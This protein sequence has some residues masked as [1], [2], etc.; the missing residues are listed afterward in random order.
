MVATG[1][2]APCT[3][4]FREVTRL[5][6]QFDGIA[7]SLPAARGPGGT[8]LT[9]TYQPG[10]V[11]VWSAQGELIRVMGNGDGEGPGEFNHAS[12]LIVDADSVVNILP[13]LPYWHRYTWAGDFIETIRVPV[14]SGLG[15]AAIGPDGMLVMTTGGA[16]G[17][18]FVLWRPGIKARI[19]EGWSSAIGSLVWVSASQEMGVW[20]AEHPHYTL[21][22]HALPSGEVDFE[23]QRKVGW[24]RS[25]EHGYSEST[26]I[27]FQLTVDDRGLLWVWTE[28][29]DSDAPST[30]RPVP[31]SPE[32]VD[33]EV[34][35]R[36]R[37]FVLEVLSTDGK[38]IAHKRFDRGQD[39]AWG[40]TADF[41]VRTEDDPLETLTIVE[42]ILVRR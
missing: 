19:T 27:V 8:Y 32:E 37:D 31:Q 13:G 15:E 14:M 4:E 2:D 26:A 29:P 33:P 41:W 39:I 42:P 18:R 5:Q 16:Q 3:I 17:A 1:E 12:E 34:A 35:N 38:L 28:V 23:V 6:S 11:A 24:F 40:A 36:Y 22:R 21:R 30:P 7:A 9:A 25:S 20:S 10:R